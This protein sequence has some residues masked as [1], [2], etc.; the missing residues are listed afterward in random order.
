MELK[1]AVYQNFTTIRV[2]GIGT[3]A[4]ILSLAIRIKLTH[5]FYFLFLGWNLILALVPFVITMYLHTYSEVLANRWKRL[6]ISLVWLLFLPNAPYIITDF[7]HLQKATSKLIFLDFWVIATFAAT[8]FLAG[9]YSIRM[10]LVFF[11]LFY[12]SRTLKA[13]TLLICMLSGFGVY[14][15][16]F[17][18]L[19]SWDI[20][21][22]PQ[23]TLREILSSLEHPKAWATTLIFGSV[24]FLSVLV[25]DKSRVKTVSS[26]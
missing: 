13:F 5:D 14:L 17:I 4:A 20:F 21:I 19:N 3:V 22:Q 18:R 24:L 26:K 2:L 15:G 6:G 16:R 23:A 7:I 25:F 9:L 12:S 11:S 1:D 10:M 8:G